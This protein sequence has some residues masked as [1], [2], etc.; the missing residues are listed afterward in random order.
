MTIPWDMLETP[1]DAPP[2]APVTVR[3]QTLPPRSRFAEHAHDWAQVVYAVSGVLTVTLPGASFV[4]SS[5]QAA[6]L[7]PG[8]PH[9]V[10]SLHGAEFR[11]LW[12]ALEATRA[13]P[14]EPTVFAVAPLLRALIVEAAQ[15]QG[16]ETDAEYTG[17]VTGL[18][19]DQLRRA[20]PIAAGLPWP[21]SGPL[22]R[23]CEALYADPADT[24]SADD[25]GRM[26]G[27]SPRTLTRRFE[28]EV[29][30]SLRS[31]RRR[32]RL[33]KAVEMLGGGLDVTQTALDLGYGSPSA[34]IYAFRTG[35]G[36]S[37]Q[38]YM[39]GVGARRAP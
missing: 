7:P 6:W 12:I 38:A 39:N 19:L 22:S 3:A 25:W 20:D 5:E 1:A 26:L 37:P 34:F 14:Q 32:M 31:W 16:L 9:R 4:I 18:I 35:M 10:G 30:L 21:Q 8:T 28:A 36:V 27:M 2:P 15:L 11:S 23:L 33:F 17:R 13:M 24:R 29:G